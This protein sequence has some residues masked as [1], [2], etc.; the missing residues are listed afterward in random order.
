MDFST[1][2]SENQG[3]SYTNRASSAH[4]RPRIGTPTQWFENCWIRNTMYLQKI[5][6]TLGGI[7]GGLGG[8]STSID[9]EAFS[10][11]LTRIKTIKSDKIMFR[12]VFEAR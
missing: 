8:G 12:C 5:T 9:G 7:G 11:A 10:A 6:L 2:D 3:Y 1:F 4:G